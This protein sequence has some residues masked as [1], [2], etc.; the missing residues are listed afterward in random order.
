MRRREFLKLTAAATGAAAMPSCGQTPGGPG[1]GAQH[2]V[3]VVALD[4]MDPRIVD[5]LMAAGRLPN[6]KRLAQS[7]S[8]TRIGTSTPPQTPV[9]FANIISGA[10]P[11]LHQIF[12][13]IHRDP[14][15]TGSGLA[16]MP[17]F[18]TAEAVSPE[19]QWVLPLG[20]WQ[21]PLSG[22]ETQ[23]LRR[24]P[25]FWDY[26]VQRGID[27]EIYYLP[28]NYP[29]DDV[30]GPGNF[31]CISG[32]GT[33]DL[34]GGYG[35]FTLFTAHVSQNGQQVSGGKFAFMPMLNHRGQGELVGPPNFLRR[36][37]ES[38]RVPPLSAPFEVVRDARA[39]VAKIR[40]SG[41]TILLNEG[42][43]S[44]W[45]RIDFPTGIPGA[46][47]LAAM[48]APTTLP[49][50]VRF[51]LKQVHP[52]LELY[53][54]PINIDPLEPA[55]PISS[56]AG[57]A[58]E[59][60]ERHGR[61]Y[62]LGIPE[63]TKALRH[64]A[65]NEDQFLQQSELAMQE[66]RQ[67]YREAIKNFGS[68]CLFFYFGATDLVQH[69]FWR[70]RDPEHPG[71]DPE[72]AQ[73]Y[74]KVID[75]LYVDADGIVGEALDSLTENDTLL[76]FSDHGFTSFRRGFHLNSWLLEN[77]FVSL[78]DPGRQRND[79]LFMGVDWSRTRAYGLGMNALY[80]N[81]ASREKFGIVEP[82][83]QQSL[84]EEI[85]DRLLDERD[86]DGTQVVERV[87]IVR[88]VYPAADPAIAPDMII[89]YADGYRASWAT[90]LGGMP[91][92]LLEDNKDRW[93]GT[94]LINAD[95]VPGILFTNRKVM[96]A[97]PNLRD[98]APTILAEFGIER[99]SQ[100]TGQA[101]F[102]KTADNIGT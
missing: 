14:N 54:S 60:A 65:L 97:A 95:Q 82:A 75:D 38:G 51:H 27:A 59:L 3:L 24:G 63:D 21:L 69:M 99:P 29:T 93:S 66:R 78:M 94:H 84:L 35:E 57:F 19:S 100:M 79:P 55:N 30:S 56:P 48:S 25:A 42:E 44:D 47:V 88:D 49:G 102:P 72:Q 98:L 96:A 5:G 58:A 50:I 53:A 6:F 28:S 81:A 67:Q 16:V 76:V 37:D 20:H 10:D 45:V 13:F 71:F 18:S 73:Q 52:T 92:A 87:D 85:R 8:Y 40:V 89:G 74:G 80:L 31:R 36:P 33:P 64:G 61:F 17:S 34:L 43:W 70:D 12:D 83:V 101:L 15:P 1:G 39:S 91:R 32:M 4:G 22:G 41:R 86:T 11:G 2:R 62:T 9:A 23:L 68:G 46:P 77:N 90:T 7:G 26:L